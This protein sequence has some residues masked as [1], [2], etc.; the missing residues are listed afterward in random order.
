MPTYKVTDPQTGRTVKLTGDS[1]PTEQELEQIFA[2]LKQPVVEKEKTLPETLGGIGETALTMATGAVAEPLA[3]LA[4]L[5]SLPFK[6]SDAGGVVD[7]VRNAL[8]Y[9]P[10]TEAGQEYLQNVANAPVIKQIGE[11]MQFASKGLGDV[12]YDVTGSPAAAAI[13]SAIPEAAMQTVGYRAPTSAAGRLT[14]KADDLALKAQGM[15]DNTAD[16]QQ[17]A[18][19]IQGGDIAKV[20]DMVNPDPSF[21][22]ATKKLGVT[23]EPLPSFGSMNPEYRGVEMGLSAIPGSPIAAQGLQFTQELAKKA[24]D[25][26]SEFGGSIDKPE[27][28]NQFRNK[29]GSTISKMEDE[30]SNA[31]KAIGERLDKKSAAQ[32]VKT[33]RFIQDEYADLALGLDD[34]DVPTIVKDVIKSLSPRQK[35]LDDGTVAQVPAT[36]ANMDKTRKQ[37]GAALYKKEGQFKDADSALLGRLYANITEDMDAMAEAQ[38]LSDEVRQAKAIVA[39]RKGIEQKMQDLLGKD[40][41]KDVVPEVESALTRLKSGKIEDFR[42]TMQLIPAEDRQSVMMTSL[43][44]AFRGTAQGADRF[45]ATQYT[46]WHADTL[47]NP[48]V[49]KEFARYLPEGALEK[50]DAMNVVANGIATALKDKKPT[51]VVNAMFNEKSGIM[52]NLAGKAAGMAANVAT[53]GL[54]GGVVQDIITA[55]TNQ[56]KAAGDLLSDPAL[57][58]AIRQGVEAGYVSGRAKAARLDAANKLLERSKKYQKWASTLNDTDKAKLS[59]VGAVNFILE[60]SEQEEK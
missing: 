8:T 17:A 53:K 20:A 19:V 27:V 41:G 44:K 11:G 57:A 23:S 56:A 2:Q 33:M 3:G 6:G 54:A 12:A 14:S 7:T 16:A 13:A 45:D 32:P 51:G 39:Q 40:L 28:S 5:A 29:M 30:A 48:S 60:T 1:P 36:Y 59:S 15:I 31:Y 38:G 35:A 18:K 21:Y 46:K 52:R 9:Q 47:R 37:I 26:I 34:P 50:M 58:Q 10:K 24:D 22:A 42:R 43:N 55:S 49:R 4:G 25:I